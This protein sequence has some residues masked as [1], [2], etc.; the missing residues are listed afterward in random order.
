MD[1]GGLAAVVVA[2]LATFFGGV[3]SGAAGAAGE[4]LGHGALERLEAIYGAVKAR[5]ARDPFQAQ[6]LDRWE[7]EPDSR[8]R[9]QVLEG[10]L[11]EQAAGD[12]AFAT[13]L[14]G[15]IAALQ[16]AGGRGA[17]GLNSGAIAGQDVYQSGQLVAGRDLT[18]GAPGSPPDRHGGAS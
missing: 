18:S 13:E 10:V 9:R 6:A 2:A 3:A 11:M 1:P 5:L 17:V 12:R 4:Q 8:S 15:L 7:A 14:A 16:A